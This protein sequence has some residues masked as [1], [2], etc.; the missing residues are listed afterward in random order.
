MKL[1]SAFSFDAFCQKNNY[2]F[3]FSDFA[4]GHLPGGKRV[5]RFAIVKTDAPADE[6][7]KS[8]PLWTIREMIERH[9]YAPELNK[10]V[11]AILEW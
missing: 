5:R 7:R 4:Y 11:L 10:P 8:F 1:F 9:R 6:V 3:C 2:R